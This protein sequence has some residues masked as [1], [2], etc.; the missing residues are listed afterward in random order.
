MT[1]IAT[2]GSNAGAE[3]KSWSTFYVLIAAF[4]AIV[5]G[6]VAFGN[7]G[8]TDS[9]T[10][11]LLLRIPDGL[12]RIVHIPGWAAATVSL[13]LFGL[14]MAGQGFYNDVAWHVGLGRDKNLFTAPHTGI[15]VGLGMIL[16]SGVVGV[17]FASLQ[18]IDTPLRWRAVRIPWST[19]PL[20]ALGGAAV[21]GFPL[22]ELWHRQF[23]VD[24]TMWSPTHMLMILGAAFVGIASWLVLADAGVKPHD[25][26]WSLGIHVVAAWLTLQG[27][28]APLG[29]FAFGVP[30]FQQIFHPMILVLASAFAFTAM[31]LVLG[32]WWGIGIA[33]FNIV[34]TTS[35]FAGKHPLIETKIVGIYVFSAIA[36]ELVA[37]IVGTDNRL[38]FAIASGL[39]VA[40]LGF[41]GDYWWNANHAY[42]PWNTNLLP[43]ALV[44]GVIVGVAAALLATA[45]ARAAGH[46]D[47][48]API[49]RPVLAVAGL[50]LLVCLA[51][52]MPRHVGDVT[53]AVQITDRAGGFAKVA[54]TLTP[55]DA[56]D[57]ARFF[58]AGAWAGGGLELADMHK[59]GPGRYVSDG[60][61]P[62]S[63][64]W[65]SMLRL[66]RGGEMMAIALHLPGDAELHK[67]ELVAADR[68]T[69]FQPEPKY[70]LR[71]QH[72]GNNVFKNTV[73]ALLVG[74]VV[75][76]IAAF[77][78]AVGKIAPKAPKTPPT[79]TPRLRVKPVAA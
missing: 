59:V 11:R 76:W 2:I 68:T 50:T 33:A 9:R 26:R 79:S 8:N 25:S 69:K 44:F 18:R 3:L 36:V 30:Q 20:L 70:L 66:H 72:G 10:A 29:E 56:A 60:R 1:L 39:G 67:P 71:E 55:P 43:D 14:F 54:V 78:V 21:T 37:F 58:Q 77:T 62:V 19:L 61:I 48:T 23:G 47:N 13:A 45:F 73:Y 7:S 52:P 41:A 34:S 12:E 22:D 74:V 27:L 64:G 40:T 42:Q 53:G 46:Q 31:R 32:R 28:I 75:M 5:A 51:L 17:L 35:L 16:M 49:P 63:G 4:I 15:V 6:L 57:H 38:R 24:V 65:K